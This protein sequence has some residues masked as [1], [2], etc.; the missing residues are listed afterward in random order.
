MLELGNDGGVFRRRCLAIATLCHERSM[1]TCK[2]ERAEPRTDFAASRKA[3]VLA[4]V[5]GLDD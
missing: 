3:Q 2:Q 4:R 5:V 1:S